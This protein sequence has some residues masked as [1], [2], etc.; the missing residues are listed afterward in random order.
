MHGPNGLRPI[1][2]KTLTRR[3]RREPCGVVSSPV[4]DRWRRPQLPRL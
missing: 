1:P 4:H 3:G 2:N